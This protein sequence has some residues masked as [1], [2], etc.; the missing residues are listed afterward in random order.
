MIFCYE[1]DSNKLEFGS[2]LFLVQSLTIK[3]SL[4][5]AKDSNIL[6]KGGGTNTLC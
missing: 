6:R 3:L 2:S 4:T 5:M 1:R